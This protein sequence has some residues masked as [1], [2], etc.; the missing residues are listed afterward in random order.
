M[1]LRS[2]HLKSK[3]GEG[4]LDR[5]TKGLLTVSW[6]E[7]SED[8]RSAN[9]DWLVRVT[10]WAEVGQAGVRATV[11]TGGCVHR[12]VCVHVSM[13]IGE[14]VPS[15]YTWTWALQTHAVAD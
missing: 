11:Y 6:S 14:C 4:I 5:I 2:P 13:P 1:S 10:H 3:S 7:D 9:P 12:R 15:A 8:Q